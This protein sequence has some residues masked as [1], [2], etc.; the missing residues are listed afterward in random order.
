[1]IH[2]GCLSLPFSQPC[3]PPCVSASSQAGFLHHNQ[4]EQHTAVFPSWGKSGFL[5]SPRESLK[6]RHSQGNTHDDS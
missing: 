5:Q 3:L 1:M 2:Q 4:S 6:G